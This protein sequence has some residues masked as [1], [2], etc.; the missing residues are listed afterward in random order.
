MIY[1]DFIRVLYIDMKT[2]QTR[3]ED[4]KDLK[5][6]MGGAGVASKLLEENMHP[7]L[8]PLDPAQ[9]IV[10]AIGGLSTIF[11]VVTK[12]VA[13]FISPLTGEM[14]ESHAGGRFAASIFAAGYDAFVITNKSDIPVFLKISDREVVF[15]DARAMW[16]SEKDHTG[17]IIRGD[18]PE[19]S[20]KRSIVHIG[21]AGEN[22]C[23]FA[24]VTVER[25]RHF[26]RLGLG[27]CF[28]SKHLKAIN[29]F[30]SRDIPINNFKEYLKTYRTI[31]DTCVNS[32]VMSKYHDLGTPVNVLVMNELGSLPTLNLQ[33]NR[34]EHA[35]KVSGEVFSEHHQV[36]KVSCAGCPVGCIHIAQFRRPFAEKGYE[37][38]TV[39]VCYDYELIF[40][41]GTFLGLKD[42]QEILQLIEEVEVTGMDAMSAGVVLGWATEALSS[43]LVK[44]EDTIVPIKFGSYK[45]YLDAIN[46]LAKPPN[47][48]YKNLAKGCRYAAEVYGGQDFA[49]Q[50]AGNEMPGYHTGYGSLIG[51]AVGAR[52]SHLDNAGYS[53]DQKMTTN[54][55]DTD[56]YADALFKEEI[57]RCMLNSLTICLFARGVYNRDTIRAAY[58]SIGWDLT[59]DDI[60]AMARRIYATKLRI[61][62]ALGFDLR[63]IKIPKRF[64][65]TPSIHGN[66]NEK[67]AYELLMKYADRVE[68]MD[69][70][71]EAHA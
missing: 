49:M 55:I 25:Y 12:T 42:P 64:F 66:M 48:F 32:G 56:E 21:S 43:G 28:G 2:R 46:Y 54:D 10:F 67:V 6:Y 36:R 26:G 19:H 51:V 9:P 18:E 40:S 22:M 61:K 37:Y 20:G 69:I 52:H 15:R 5:K 39:N 47:E 13:M 53:L 45:E 4:R 71:E 31:Y 59:D 7:N 33:Q 62:K 8:P 57:E 60:T 11:P 50:L 34:F 30:G 16:G 3:V 24:C 58:S 70:S 27:A 14:G 38:E 35:D 23:A 29:V 68:Q 41:L 63:D 17:R 1:Q 44:E 65:D